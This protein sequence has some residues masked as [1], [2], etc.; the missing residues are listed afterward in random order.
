MQDHPDDALLRYDFARDNLTAVDRQVQ[1]A[2]LRTHISSAIP[3]S[4]AEHQQLVA[5]L[6]EQADLCGKFGEAAR[7]L[8]HALAKT[9]E[10][11]AVTAS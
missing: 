11:D 6:H 4:T 3:L 8:A 7:G 5:L 9:G 1:A 2:Q 10:T